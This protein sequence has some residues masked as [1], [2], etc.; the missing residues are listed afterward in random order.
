MQTNQTHDLEF[1]EEMG[2]SRMTTPGLNMKLEM[3]Y[4]PLCQKNEKLEV[5]HVIAEFVV[6]N[7][8]DVCA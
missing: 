2:R 5:G 7:P 1:G 4:C 6:K 3:P 8:V